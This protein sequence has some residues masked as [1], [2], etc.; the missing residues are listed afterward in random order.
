MMW[1]PPGS[2][3][4]HARKLH[5][6][7]CGEL[8]GMPVCSHKQQFQFSCTAGSLTCILC[9]P[10]LQ[11]RWTSRPCGKC[12]VQRCECFPGGL[13]CMPCS[14]IF[15]EFE[16]FRAC[17]YA[18]ICSH[19]HCNLYHEASLAYPVVAYSLLLGT[20]GH[21]SMQ[22]YAGMSIVPDSGKPFLHTLQSNSAGSGS[23]GDV[24]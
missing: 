19:L 24:Q 16:N 6:S 22:P 9:S 2:P 5:C 20:S 18:A 21:A 13:T 8:P 14:C 12:D 7:C 4:L 3:Y 11:G 10:S 17:Q 1:E 15:L 23:P